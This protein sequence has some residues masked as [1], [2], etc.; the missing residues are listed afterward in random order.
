MTVRPMWPLPRWWYISLLVAFVLATTL[1]VLNPLPAD[2][3]TRAFA[4]KVRTDRW[5]VATG[6]L[7]FGI[8]LAHIVGAQARYVLAKLLRLTGDTSE[9]DA[10]SP[11]VV[12]VCEGIL[13]PSALFIGKGDFIGVWLAIKVAGQWT[14]WA[15]DPVGAGAADMDA[16]NQGRRRF[17]A[18]LVGNA[19]SIMFGVLV[20]LALK[21]YVGIPAA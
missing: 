8:I 5:A 3:I 2:S 14:R 4:R 21:V 13:Y 7:L 9:A 18:F 1:I 16:L 6:I 15:G 12:G 20:W 10:W 17:N 11:A 19:I